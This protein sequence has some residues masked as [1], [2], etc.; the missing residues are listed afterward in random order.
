MMIE[1]ISLQSG[2]LESLISLEEALNKL[3]PA[4]Y[5]DREAAAQVLR[6]GQPLRTT[7]YEYRLHVD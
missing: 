7:A 3:V 6:D 5:I 1:R 4:Y 2:E